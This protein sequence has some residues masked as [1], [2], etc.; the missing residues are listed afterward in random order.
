MRQPKPRSAQMQPAVYRFAEYTLDA[1]RGV[2]LGPQGREAELRPK[3]AEVLHHLA[4]RAGQVVSREE[5]M[6]AVWP[7]VFVTDDN[8]TQCVAEIRRALGGTGASLLRTLPKRGYLLAAEVTRVETSAPSDAA[9][10][11][12]MT[13]AV[14]PLR[15]SSPS[16]ALAAKPDPPAWPS[17][18][19]R[20]LTVLFSSLVGIR[21]IRLD[22]EDL[23]DVVAAYQRAIVATVEGY[24]GYIA[25]RL[26]DWI[27]GYFGW[28]TAHED[29]AERAVRA[30]L[31]GIERVAELAIGPL[32]SGQ[33]RARIGI[34]TGLVVVGDLIGRGEMQEQDVVG[35]TPRRAAR[36]QAEAEP[37]TVMID[38]ATHRLTGALFDHAEFGDATPQDPSDSGRRFRVLGESRIESRFEALHGVSAHL[39]LIGREEELDLL[40]RRWRQVCSGEGRVVLIRGEAGIGKSRLTV[41][42]Q[43]ALAADRNREEMVFYCSPQHTHSLLRPIITRLERAAGF[44]PGEAPEARLTK[45]EALLTPLS[46]P[47]EDVT[48]I[49]ELMS[50]PTLGR[51][52]T[53]DLPPL[54][55]RERLLEALLRRGRALAAR[56]PV[57][58]VVEDAHWLDPTT[59]ELLDL[60][61]AEAASMALLLVITHRPEFNAGPWLDLPQVTLLQLK[62]LGRAEHTALLW[63]VAG[64]KAL[65]AEVEAE[66][67][68]HTDG[69]PLFVEEVA[70]AVLESGLLRE[71]ADRWVLEGPLPPIAVPATLR[72]SLVARLDHL[73]SVRE[74][75]QVGAVIGREFAFD[76]LAAV[77][78]L[79]EARLCEALPQLEGADLVH[80]RGEPPDAVYVFKHALVQD[81]AYGTLLREQR[82][83]LHRR[84][85]EAIARLRP[86][87]AEREP[88]LLAWHYARAGLVDPAIQHWRRAGERSVAR[89]AN[90]E[91]I[92][93]FQSALELLERLAPGDERDRLEAELR[94][95][96]AVPL[97][98]I[99]GF[100]SQAVETCALRA[101]ELGERLPGWP[102]RFAAHRVAWN[103]CLLR[104]PAA[105]TV[106]LA[107]DLFSFAE[108][109]G[110]PVRVAAACRALGYSLFIAG[111]PA[112][113]DPLLARG[114]AVADDLPDF[115]FAPYGEDPRIVCRIYRGKAY[116]L[117][118]CPEAGLRLAEEGLAR[119]F[120]SN[121]PHAIAWSLVVN[122]QI[123]GLLRDAARAERI[124]AEAIE[125]ALRHRFPQWLAFAQQT[126]G[127]ALC[128][129]GQV[130]QGLAL[131][132][133]GLQRL[134]ATGGK[135]HTTLVHCFLADG[136]MLANRPEAAFRHLEAART[137]A[138]V[139]GE[140]YMAAEIHRLHAGAL[141]IQGASAEE[142]NRQ[143]CAA[144]KV[145]RRQAAKLWELRAARDLARLW[146][147]QGRVT[148]ARDLLAPVYA[149]FA[150][151]FALPDLL[152]AKALLED[153]GEAVSGSGAKPTPSTAAPPLGMHPAP[154]PEPKH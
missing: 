130:E 27:I 89:F 40:L 150:K 12:D 58:A 76:L 116:S 23:R 79:P 144:L 71:E 91:A 103:S 30:G 152:E 135:L 105:R 47:S 29:D 9:A 51:W 17:A 137:H 16:E 143:L 5:L 101:K 132:E 153:M 2:V 73:A 14:P 52:P 90:R 148:E 110:D 43:E 108:Q 31:A 134:H 70:K 67:L 45:L 112:D 46:P 78:G 147:E 64:G 1:A 97:I 82:R 128:Q 123:S 61:V 125:V 57:L 94:L 10:S 24:G 86:E 131:L 55:R 87:A 35:E 136:C 26:G 138:E 22:P 62:R 98:A 80:R 37:G 121:N 18:E 66:I 34:A 109:S 129:L 15:P 92:G 63:H 4:E 120:A 48:L 104:Q 122:S 100:G 151:G 11:G 20:Q 77:S 140:Q 25:K 106:A 146:R 7:G 145:A 3:T 102:G 65:P 6:Q 127:W 149:A 36:L 75:A 114:M 113:A 133:E 81:A 32:A 118:G 49:A 56:R 111:A 139:Y 88:Q 8:I 119:A 33:L 83:D 117:L 84:A 28:P 53:L 72:A 50:V 19:R 99:H 96:Q 44:V 54:R 60:L 21:S 126:H 68:S 93:H 85:A 74:V 38:A 39:P 69:V 115:A 13:A 95:A 124:A 154:R 41:A 42:L 142:E 59:R 107:R 141:R